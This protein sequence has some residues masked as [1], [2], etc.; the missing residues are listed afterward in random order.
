MT[1]G[2]LAGL[3]VVVAAVW[4]LTEDSPRSLRERF[5]D[6]ERLVG[7]SLTVLRACVGTGSLEPERDSS[8]HQFLATLVSVTGALVP[9]VLLGVV[10]VK[11]FALRPFVWRQRAS[12]SQAWTA[13][14]P[15]YARLHADSDDAIIAVRF[16]SRFDNLSVVDLTARAHLRY[17]ERSPH[18]GSLVIYKQWLKVLDAKGDLADER[19]WLAVERGAPFTVWIPLEA[20]V[21]ELPFRRIQGKDLSQ[22]HGVKLLVRVSAR[23]VGLGTEVTDERWFDLEAGDFELGRFVPLEPDLGVDVWQ[24]QGW[25]DF[26][27]LMDPRPNGEDPTRPAA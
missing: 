2:A 12:I 18:D 16:Y 24:W 21:P 22:S 23:T 10:L 13:D 19:A 8:W 9:A 11:L 26:D 25:R 1:L 27:G 4:T 15:G 20:P 6:G 3:A 5:T 7:L 17:L 14:F